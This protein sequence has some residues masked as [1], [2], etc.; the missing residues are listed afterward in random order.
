M[1]EN[2]SE[3]SEKNKFLRKL[4]SSI[5]DED[6]IKR[7][8]KRK[9]AISLILLAATLSVISY[10]YVGIFFALRMPEAALVILF[11]AVVHSFLVPVAIMLTG[12]ISFAYSIFQAVWDLTCQ[13][14]IF[15]MPVI[16]IG[17]S[18]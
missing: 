9:R 10:S 1:K 16:T 18:S 7:D 11:Q 4:V 15:K 3:I 14:F 2:Q 12:N 8:E 5:K 6:F 13:Y 17:A